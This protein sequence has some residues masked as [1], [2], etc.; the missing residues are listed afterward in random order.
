MKLV[1]S[2]VV[3][4]QGSQRFNYGFASSSG[5][6]GVYG[7]S[8]SGKTTLLEVICGLRRASAGRVEIDGQ[9][10]QDG[11]TGTFMPPEQRRIGYVPQDGALFP[12]LSVRANLE[13][14]LRRKAAVAP[15]SGMLSFAAVVDLLEL[16]GL[17]ERG[18]SG[19]SGGERQRVAIGRALLSKPRLLLLDEPLANLDPLR[20]ETILPFLRRIREELGLPLLYVSHTRT[21]IQSLCEELLVLDGG[22]V[23]QHGPVADVLRQPASPEVARIL[24]TETILPG[25]VLEAGGGTVRVA[26]GGTQVQAAESATWRPGDAVLVCIRAEDVIL[27][28]GHQLV[29]VSARNRLPGVLLDAQR[30][31]PLVMARLDCGFE[32]TVAITAQAA[33]ELEL[34]PGN[35]FCAWI[36]VGAV[37]LVSA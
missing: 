7:P 25:R 8:G 18:T 33:E 24:G 2:G 36:K 23:L 1:L 28:Q 14:G 34:R 19:L 32:L 29:G 9:C 21:E 27:A 11:V 37:H 20:R 5:C 17:L 12:H 13:Y 16:S 35:P 4:P 26:V 10:L 15:G 3:L 6:L 22:C 31:G 30:L